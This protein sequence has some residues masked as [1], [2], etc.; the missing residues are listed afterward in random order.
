MKLKVCLQMEN[1]MMSQICT[2]FSHHT[3]SLE[4]KPCNRFEAVQLQM[5]RVLNSLKI[6]PF[7][8]YFDFTTY[9][10]VFFPWHLESLSRLYW[11]H[12]HWILLPIAPWVFVANCKI[13]SAGWLTITGTCPRSKK[14]AHKASRTGYPHYLNFIL[15]YVRINYNRPQSKWNKLN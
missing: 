11:F 15:E 1:Q 7:F 12:C 10:I 14:Q 5:G 6:W 9:R 13:F 2:I 4:A 3:I 8:T